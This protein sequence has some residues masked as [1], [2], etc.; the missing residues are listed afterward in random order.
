MFNC[1][2]CSFELQQGDLTTLPES[3]ALDLKS[4]LNQTTIG[5]VKI[6]PEKG[7]LFIDRVEFPNEWKVGDEHGLIHDG[8]QVYAAAHALTPSPPPL[9]HTLLLSHPPLLSSDCAGRRQAHR[10]LRMEVR[11]GEWPRRSAR[12]IDICEPLVGVWLCGGGEDD[13]AESDGHLG[14]MLYGTA[15]ITRRFGGRSCRRCHGRIYCRPYTSNCR[16]N[17]Q[18]TP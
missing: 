11:G 13:D 1:N 12:G 4:M 16:P 6:A 7:T 9:S 14:Q 15:D 10:P 8:L 2:R 17:Y 18:P 3:E 5:R